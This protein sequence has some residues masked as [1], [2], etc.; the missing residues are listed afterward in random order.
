MTHALDPTRAET[1]DAVA[2]VV[3]E[4]YAVPVP[5]VAMGPERRAAAATLRAL[6][7]LLEHT[8][9]A[10][11]PTPTVITVEAVLTPK[12]EVDEQTRVA[13]VLAYAERIGRKAHVSEVAGSVSV[14]DLNFRAGMIEGG[15]RVEYWMLA[16]LDKVRRRYVP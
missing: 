7:G 8:T 2:A 4:R 5:A 16:V 12:E 6:A 11:L 9:P 1:L 3:R 10:D 15:P 13:Q 14:H